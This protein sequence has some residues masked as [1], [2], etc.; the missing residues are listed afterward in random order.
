[1][2]TTTD[3]PHASHKVANLESVSDLTM[4]VPCSLIPRPYSQLFNVTV[5]LK[6]GWQRATLK[7]LGIGPGNEAILYVSCS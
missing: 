2:T 7:K 3:T 4:H 6:S 5:A 1:M